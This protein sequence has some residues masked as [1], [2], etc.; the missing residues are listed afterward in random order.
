M[1]EKLGAG[2]GKI[3]NNSWRVQEVKKIVKRQ[4]QILLSSASLTKK[5]LFTER[6]KNCY[7]YVK[8]SNKN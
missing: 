2:M 8:V 1:F 5:C 4:K 7:L 6:G 3:I